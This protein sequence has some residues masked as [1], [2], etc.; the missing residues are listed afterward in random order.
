MRFPVLWLKQQPAKARVIGIHGAVTARDARTGKRFPVVSGMELGIGTT[1]WTSADANLTLQFA[2]GSRMQLQGDS[3]LVLDKLSTYGETGMTDT[4]M[5]L[6]HGRTSSGVKRMHGPASRFIIETPNTVSSVRGTR[7]RIGS[8]GRDSMAEVLEGSVTVTRHGHELV[9]SSGQ[10][11]I[12]DE[13]HGET[14]P[15]SQTL[16]PSPDPATI[17]LDSNAMP[18]QLAWSAVAG[19]QSYRIQVGET[20]EFI[21]LVF[22]RVTDATNIALAGVANGIHAIRVRAIDANGIEGH[23]AVVERRTAVQPP[24]TIEPVDGD[25]IDAARPRFRWAAMGEHARYHVQLAASK[26]FDALLIDESGLSAAEFRI[27]Q[28]LPPG[29]YAWRV[30]AVDGDGRATDFSDGVGFSL[31]APGTGPA[32]EPD[33]TIDNTALHLRWP[34]GSP[35]QRFRFQLARK[36]DFQRIEV[37]RE[38]DDNQIALPELRSGT[39]Y[40]RV[41]T[42]ESDGYAGEFGPAQRIKLGCLPCRWF[43]GGAV[44]LLLAL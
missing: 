40:A 10:G 26:Q 2:D 6:P 22:D 30:A 24:F 31:D 13:R 3:E 43:A 11:S 25:R 37:D 44:V 34:A 35:G 28:P 29:D 9:L 33:A 27:P 32:L 1:L 21:T 4:R 14:A 16:L 7:F 20:P 38:I 8:D 23:D 19:A 15:V 42:L 12:S 5:R 36:P 39:W 17:V 18:A 41:Q